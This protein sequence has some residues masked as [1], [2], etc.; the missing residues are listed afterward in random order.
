M[1][2]APL[3]QAGIIVSPRAHYLEDPPRVIGLKGVLHTR[4]TSQ[5]EA[6]TRVAFAVR[7][8][9]DAILVRGRWCHDSPI[10]PTGFTATRACFDVALPS[11]VVFLKM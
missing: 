11:G 3:N 5:S 2:H 7:N 4:A 1:V 8:S 6:K 9:N 10:E